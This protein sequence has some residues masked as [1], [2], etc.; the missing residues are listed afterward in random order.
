MF[1]YF[2]FLLLSTESKAMAVH[3][4]LHLLSFI[5]EAVLRLL[6]LHLSSYRFP[7]D[8]AFDSYPRKFS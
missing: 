6:I 1:W 8:F 4:L 7:G 5:L 2:W 3:T